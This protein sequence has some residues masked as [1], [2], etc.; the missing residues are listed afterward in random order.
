MVVTHDPG[1]WFEEVLAALADQDYPSLSVLVIDAGSD[2]DPTDRV[3]AV[4]PDAYV[5]R[6]DDNPGFGAAANEVLAIVEGAAFYLLCHDDVALEPGAVRA[7]VRGGL[8]VERRHRRPEAGHAG[9]TPPGCSRS[10][11]PV[12]K[13][14]HEVADRRARRARP[15]AARRRPR[16]V[17]RARA[18]PR[19]CGPTSSPPSAASTPPSPT[20]ARTSTCA[21]GPRW[22]APGCS[23]PR[24]RWPA[25][26]EALGRARAASA[27]DRRR[28][29]LRHRL[30]TV[31]TCYGAAATCCGCCPRSSLLAVVEVVYALVAGRRR[32][33]GR[34]RRR[35]AVE[36]PATAASI[37]AARRRRRGRSAPCPTA[38]CAGSRSRGSARFAAFLRGQLG[39]GGDDRVRALDPL[40]RRPGRVAAPRARCARRVVGV[41]RPRARAARRAAAT[42]SSARRPRSSTCPS[43]PAG[44][45]PLLGE[46]LSGWRRA[47]LGSE[48]PAADRLRPARRW[49]APCCSAPW[50]LLQRLLVRRARCVLGPIGARPAG[51]GATGSRRAPLGR[52]PSSTP[53]SRC[54]T[55]PS[56]AAGGV[57]CVVWSA[58]P[59]MRRPP[60]PGRRRRALPPASGHRA[61]RRR[62]AGVAGR[63]GARPRHRAGRRVRPARRRRCRW[64]LAVALAV[65][66]ARRRPG[67][68]APA[69][70]WPPAAAPPLI[71]GV[72]HLPWTLDSCLPGATWAAVGGVRPPA[73]SARRRPS[74]CA[75]R[76]GPSAPRPRLGVRWSRPRCRLLIGRGWRCAWAVRAWV[77]AA[78]RLGARRR[79]RVGGSPS[80]SA[81]PSCCSPRPRLR[82]GRSPPP[83]AW[84][85]S[86]STCP[87][88]ASAGARWR[89][90]S[91]PRWRSPS[92]RCPSLGA[93][94]DG[95]LG[96]ARARR[97]PRCSA[98][99]TP[100][101][102]PRARSARCGSA[103]PRCC[104]SPAGSSTTAGLGPHRRGPAHRARPVGGLARRRRP[105]LVAD[106]IELRRRRRTSRLGRLLGADGRPLRRRGRGRPARRRPAC[107][108][109][110]ADARRRPRRAARPGRG[111]GRRGPARLPQQAWFPGRADARLRRRRRHRRRLPRPPPRVDRRRR[112]CRCSPTA[113]APTASRAPVAGDVCGSAAVVGALGARRRRPAA[114]ADDGVRLRQHVHRRATAATATLTLRDADRTGWSS[115][116]AGRGLGAGR[117]RAVRARRA[118][119]APNGG[120]PMTGPHGRSARAGCWSRRPRAWPSWSPAAT[121]S[122]AAAS[123][124]D[125]R[126]PSSPPAATWPPRR[127]RRRARRRPGTAPA[128]PPRDDGLGRPQRHRRQPR[129]RAGHGPSPSTA[130]A[131]PAT[132]GHRRRAGAR[133]SS[134]SPP[135]AASQSVSP[136]LARGAV[137]R[138]PRRGRRRRGRRRARRSGASG[139]LDAAPCAS[140]PSPTWYVAAGATTRDATE[141]SCC[142]TRSPTTPSST[143]PSPPRRRAGAAGVHAASSCPAAGSS[144][145]TS[146]PWCRATRRS[147]TSVQSPGPGASSSSASS[148]STARRARPGP[149]SPPAAPAPAP[150]WHL[151]DGLLRRGRHRGGHRLQP[152]RRSGRGRRRG[153][154]STRR[155]DPTRATVVEP[156]C[157][158]CRP[159]ASPRSTCTTRTGCPPASATAVDRAQPER[160]AGG[161]RAVDALRPPAPRAG[162]AADL[163]SP[164]VATRW[165]SA[166]GST[167]DGRGRVP[168]AAST[169]RPTPSPGSR[170]Q[171]RRRAQDIP[172]AGPRGRRDPESGRAVHRP[173]PVHQPRRRCRSSSSRRC[174]SSSS[175]G[176]YPGFGGFAQSIL[177]PAV[178]TASVPADRLSGDRMRRRR[179]R[180][181]RRRPAALARPPMAER[182]GHRRPRPAAGVGR[183]LERD[184]LRHRQLGRRRG[185]AGRAAA[186]RSCRR[187]PTGI[188]S[189]EAPPARPRCRPP[190]CRARAGR[191][192]RRT[193]VVRRALRRA[194]PPARRGRRARS[195]PSTS[196]STEGGGRCQAA[197]HAS[198]RRRPSPPSTA[199]RGR[200][201]GDAAAGRPCRRGPARGGPTSTGPPTAIPTRRSA[202]AR[203][204]GR[205]HQPADRATAVAHLGRRPARQPARRRVHRRRARHPRLGA[206]R[207]GSGR[208]RPR[209]GTWPSTSSRPASS[210]RP[211]P[212]S[213]PRRHDRRSGG[214]R[215][216]RRPPTSSGTRSSPWCARPRS[217][218][219]KPGCAVAAGEQ[220]AYASGDANPLVRWLR[221]RSRRSSYGPCQTRRPSST[222]LIS[223]R[224]WSSRE[225]ASTGRWRCGL[226]GVMHDGSGREDR[227]RRRVAELHDRVAVAGCVGVGDDPVDAGGDHAV[228]D[229]V[230]HDPGVDHDVAL[231]RHGVDPRRPRS[232]PG[233]P[234]G[235]PGQGGDEV[236]V[237]VL[238]GPHVLG[239][240]AP[241]P[242]TG[243]GWPG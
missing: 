18:L 29:R 209:A 227:P 194:A 34:P 126:R 110:P 132:P 143:S 111:R 24:P 204:L 51:C 13:T 160:R 99:S 177:V 224:T 78:R 164:V 196:G 15:G 42:T 172:I 193:R 131:S 103:T 8:P 198:L 206:R 69:G 1:P 168:R 50:R 38:R 212:A 195:S 184:P 166:V 16:R 159:P 190:G 191:A 200:C 91:P 216:S 37:R 220:P 174:R 181:G 175:A 10:G 214:R 123:A 147:S 118:R 169:R 237:A 102:R 80:A 48:A 150:V 61:T 157:C 119:P 207:A 201:A 109:L 49:P 87:A 9:T 43:S 219:T 213:R 79:R 171:R 73:P 115:R 28:L 236:D 215:R 120:R 57:G 179:P 125:R 225:P 208:A 124:G 197:L 137:R 77:L 83:S 186:R 142:S 149:T 27:D 223:H 68:P 7:L 54:P 107:R 116:P 180:R 202:A 231:G 67:R 88:T 11:V 71:A 182:A 70:C 112:R 12:D 26:V 133:P 47:G 243:S 93:A 45:G 188:R 90:A 21:G 163:G 32:L 178:E 95:P 187:S 92:A 104:P 97:R 151:P 35:L 155:A 62:R 138:R 134:R 82:A 66:G 238:A 113:T 173:R 30:R 239:A 76:P 75:S 141:R 233:G 128:A 96:R 64:P 129:R 144:S 22:P 84:S 44:P 36:P 85:P 40:R 106:A 176:L 165:L 108:R 152:Q 145:S 72:L 226:S 127:R 130:A 98:S 242:S 217:T 94:L 89:P 203:R 189:A 14:G 146:A 156:F 158:R 117:P 234:G 235:G 31:L 199:R 58:T 162:F 148:A 86:R 3:A 39:G 65:G 192:S 205:R 17:L 135:A 55:T 230:E 23:S 53:P 100:S 5:R 229:A 161:G 4:L 170:W 59:W 210:A 241:A 154:R 20:S 2:G 136:T 218:T 63:S 19:S 114:D 185:G 121:P 122:S 41:G 52:A 183:P 140:S 211:C 101:R 228:G 56:P 222:R 167:T 105:T 240:R 60:G 33:A 153:R 6:L 81:P 46:W 74:C 232:S 221:R 25:T 139:D